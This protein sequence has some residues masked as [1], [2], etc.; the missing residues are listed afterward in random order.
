MTSVQELTS[1]AETE[2]LGR[3]IEGPTEREMA[4]L[5]SGS[6]APDL[7]L[8]DHTGRERRLSEFWSDQP[9]LVMFWRHFGC[10]CGFERAERLREEVQAYR[11]VGLNPV[12]IAQAAATPIANKTAR[13]GLRCARTMSTVA[14]SCPRPSR[15]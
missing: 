7:V 2:W 3:W 11:E 1:A 8:P 4:D 12:I 13:S 5:P 10:W 6:K 14:R 15:A 9:A